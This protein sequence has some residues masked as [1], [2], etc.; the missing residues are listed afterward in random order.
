MNPKNLIRMIVVA[1]ALLLSG[2]IS[3]AEEISLLQRTYTV[4]MNERGATVRS[5]TNAFTEQTGVVFSY[6]SSLA[7]KRLGAVSLQAKDAS[8]EDLLSEAFRGKGISYEVV[9]STVV[10]TAAEPQQPTP[11]AAPQD[12]ARK[13]VKGQV[14]DN[15]GEPLAAAGVMVKGTN[16]GTMT[17]TNGN[18]SMETREGETLVF[19]FI[20]FT[21]EEVVV[22]RSS[23]IN[24]ALSIDQNILDD[25]VVIGYGTQSRKT[26]TTAVAK[27]VS[28]KY[29]VPPGA[30][31][32]IRS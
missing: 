26:L 25:V 16:R 20:G 27:V 9:G 5:F 18:W 12:R 6:E 28:S 23:V 13:T 22:G 10:L 19:S 3:S 14:V 2:A 8:L 31:G 15:A 1:G 11:A 24:V 7:G 30:Q 21:D 17:D 4:K 29:S 32:L